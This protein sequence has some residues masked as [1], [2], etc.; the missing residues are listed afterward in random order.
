MDMTEEDRFEKMISSS[1]EDVND[2]KLSPGFADRVVKIIQQ[3]ELKRE[4]KR[5][6]V[7]LVAGIISMIP[8][9]IFAFTKVE[10]SPGVGVFTFFSGYKGLIIFAILFV[11]ALHIIDKRLLKKQESG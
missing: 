5:D 10:F 3:N 4:S 2:F 9:L 7:W 8:A 11:T 1:L 6:R